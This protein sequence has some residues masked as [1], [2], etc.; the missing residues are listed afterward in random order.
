M[1]WPSFGHFQGRFL[2]TNTKILK[3]EKQTGLC[4]TYDASRAFLR[5]DCPIRIRIRI[6]ATSRDTW[7]LIS[8]RETIHLAKFTS[9]DV[10]G[11][12]K[13]LDPTYSAVGYC[14][15][16]IARHFLRYRRVS[17]YNPPPPPK[18]RSIAAK[19]GKKREGVSQLKL[20]S[21]G[22]RG[23]GEYSQSRLN[24]PLGL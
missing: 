14:Y 11:M 7:P 10:W 15:T 1:K 2:T 20:P 21:G 8:T 5:S 3:W 4:F 18:I 12:Y 9:K 23:M 22:Y 24:G 6:A 17:R 19:G 16:I 13:P